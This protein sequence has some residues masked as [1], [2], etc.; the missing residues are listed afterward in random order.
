MSATCPS[1]GAAVSETAKFC[2][3]CGGRVLPDPEPPRADEGEAGERTC[4]ACGAELVAGARFCH[5]CAAEAPPPPRPARIGCPTCGKEIDGSDVFC[6]YCGGSTEEWAPGEEQPERNPPADAGEGH[7]PDRLE[8][9]PPVESPGAALAEPASSDGE[10]A[11]ITSGASD[12][13]LP[14]PMAPAA[15][16]EDNSA[17]PSPATNSVDPAT[18]PLWAGTAP[19]LDDESVVLDVNEPDAKA[20]QV[21][22][23]APAPVTVSENGK[24]STQQGRMAGE[25]GTIASTDPGNGDPAAPLGRLCGACQQPVSVTAQFCRSCGASLED[26]EATAVMPLTVASTCDSC[27]EEIEGWAQFCR[28]CGARRGT[29]DADQAS[30]RANGSCQV[31]GAPAAGGSSLC[32]NCAQAVGA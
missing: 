15:T 32:V 29:E 30:Q 18:G 21:A 20:P 10:T 9:E 16:S 12:E 17:A 13:Q 6:R 31:C 8:P 7:S 4:P 14:A 28:H 23:D 27:G 3:S 5:M 2:R 1:C 22:D 25:E 11:A 19:F 24:G 26:F